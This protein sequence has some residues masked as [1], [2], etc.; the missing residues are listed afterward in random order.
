M[1]VEV[2][3]AVSV[4]FLV[5]LNCAS[6]FLDN[7][8]DTLDVA[9]VRGAF[10]FGQIV[11]LGRMTLKHKAGITAQRRA[12][13]N[14]QLGRFQRGDQIQRLPPAADGAGFAAA[15]LRPNI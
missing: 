4:N 9:H 11:Q 6:D 2:R 7:L 8:R 3:Q 5:H 12:F 1:Q 14:S 13:V 10:G 15:H